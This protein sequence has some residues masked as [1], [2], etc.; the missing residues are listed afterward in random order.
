MGTSADP[1]VDCILADQT[2]DGHLGNGYGCWRAARQW[3]LTGGVAMFEQGDIGGR[4]G[5]EQWHSGHVIGERYTCLLDILAIDCDHGDYD[6]LAI[7]WADQTSG[8][9]FDAGHYAYNWLCEGAQSDHFFIMP[10]TI[11]G[12]GATCII[13]NCY[14]FRQ[15]AAAFAFFAAGLLESVGTRY[16]E[17]EVNGDFVTWYHHKIDG[18]HLAVKFTPP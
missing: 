5:I 11:Y 10:P 15:T 2:F 9:L 12:G 6:G 1:T 14:L 13:D 7:I 16:E 17:Y 18:S 8:Y 4:T 3:E